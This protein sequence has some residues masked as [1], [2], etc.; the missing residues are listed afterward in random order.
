MK[1]ALDVR[2]PCRALQA[3]PFTYEMSLT[4]A[5]GREGAVSLWMGDFSQRCLLES[6]ECTDCGSLAGPVVTDQGMVV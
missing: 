1:G 3:V 5:L 6:P 4:L 2:Q